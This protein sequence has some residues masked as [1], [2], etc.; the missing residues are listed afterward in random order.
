MTS[1]FL[2]DLCTVFSREICGLDQE[3]RSRSGDERTQFKRYIRGS[4]SRLGKGQRGKGQML[5][6][7]RE[8]GQKL[9]AIRWGKSP[10]LKAGLIPLVIP[11]AL[12]PTSLDRKGQGHAGTS[13][14][15]R[16]SWDSHTGPTLR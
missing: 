15:G 12:A 10:G 13:K 8:R 9:Q 3:R 11:T 6:L 16:Q 4:W 5:F 7:V 1:L 14:M 2:E